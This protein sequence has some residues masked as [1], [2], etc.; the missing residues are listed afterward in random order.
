MTY[1]KPKSTSTKNNVTYIATD[2]AEKIRSSS[3]K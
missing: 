2:M 3:L 1:T